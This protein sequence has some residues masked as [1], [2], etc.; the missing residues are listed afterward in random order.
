LILPFF[1]PFSLGGLWRC[2]CA[3]MCGTQRDVCRM[4]LI[5]TMFSGEGGLQR[6]EAKKL[7]LG[8]PLQ[9]NRTTKRL[10]C[11]ST[12]LPAIEDRV[13]HIGSEKT[14]PQHTHDIRAGQPFSLGQGL[15]RRDPSC[16]ELVFPLKRPHHRQHEP[17]LG[18]F[19]IPASSVLFCQA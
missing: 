15:N 12:R 6:W 17:V 13:N 5:K 4:E 10:E 9:R 3:G 8:S 7:P 19:L 11:E 16:Y 18:E 2:H 14:Q 1:M